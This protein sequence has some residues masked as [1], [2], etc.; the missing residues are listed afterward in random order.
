MFQPILP[1]DLEQFTNSN[2]RGRFIGALGVELGNYTSSIPAI[3]F[4]TNPDTDPPK[5]YR[6][7]GLECLI[8]NP[9][10]Q[11]ARP[12][13]HNAALTEMWEIRLIQHD[14]LRSVLPAYKML[15]AKYP[16]IYLDSH[17]RANRDTSEQ[18]NLS[19]AQVAI[20][21]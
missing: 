8:F 9:T 10:P 11:S 13:H 16:D 6:T 4:V 7:S 19:V 3:W 18:L 15:L 20:I 1:I 17:I 5:N 14:R 21:R 12:L 2:I